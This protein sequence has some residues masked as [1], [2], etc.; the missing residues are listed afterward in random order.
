VRDTQHTSTTNRP[1]WR[2]AVLLL[3]L[4]PLRALTQTPDEWNDE[5]VDHFAGLWKLEGKILGQPAHHDVRAHWVLNHQFLNFQ[6]RTAANAPETEH[7]YQASWFLGYDGVSERYVMHLLDVFGGRFS[8]TLGYG[9]RDGNAIRFVFEYPDG[10]FHTT[11]RWEPE[12]NSWH[13]LMEQ[14][15]KAGKWTSFADL[16]MT[17]LPAP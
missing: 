16:T 10:P 11:L 3:A 12:S 1:C 14:K 15:D 17:R 7:H 4:V 8:E 13:W 2:L 9:T 5:L 6:E